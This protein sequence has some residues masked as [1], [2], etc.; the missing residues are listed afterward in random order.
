MPFSAEKVWK[1]LN[2]D[3]N[4]SDELWDEATEFTLKPGHLL[5]EP[6]ILFTKYDDDVIQAQV[7][8]LQ[9]RVETPAEEES[10][11]QPPEYKEQI[12]FDDFQQMDLRVAVVKKAEHIPKANKLLK[13]QIDLGM[14][15]RQIVAGIAKR[16]EPEELVGRRIIVVAN[17]APAKLMGEVSQG[18]LLAAEGDEKF[19]LLTV[20]DSLPPGSTIR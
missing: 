8:K 15:E 2:L 17:L 6:E 5:N 16:Y 9:S 12:S 13:L 18:M 19:G 7:E 1:M 14:E 10:G 20:P 11:Y 3:G 4:I